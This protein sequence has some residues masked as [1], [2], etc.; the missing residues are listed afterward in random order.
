MPPPWRDGR[1]RPLALKRRAV[2]GE[3]PSSGFLFRGPYGATS[4]SVRVCSSPTPSVRRGHEAPKNQALSTF[5][6]HTATLPIPRLRSSIPGASAAGPR[7]FWGCV[8]LWGRVVRRLCRSEPDEYWRY[9]H[10]APAVG[11]LGGDRVSL[12]AGLRKTPDGARV[13]LASQRCPQEMA[14]R[15][16]G[17]RQPWFSHACRLVVRIVDHG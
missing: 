7:F 17:W 1:V 16:T 12:T 13:T 10:G 9:R 8:V 14:D 3:L 15:L 5:L 11:A 6:G 2:D 4:W